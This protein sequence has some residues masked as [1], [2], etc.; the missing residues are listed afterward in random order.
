MSLMLII[1]IIM[2]IMILKIKLI[3]EQNSD[4]KTQLSNVSKIAKDTKNKFLVEIEILNKQINELKNNNDSYEKTIKNKNK[5]INLLERD[6]ENSGKIIENNNSEIEQLK[7]IRENYGET[8]EIKNDE[9]K[10][11][12]RII[13]DYEKTISDKNEQIEQLEITIEC[14]EDDNREY[15]E[16]IEDKKQKIKILEQTLYSTNEDIRVERDKISYTLKILNEKMDSF[17]SEE[18]YVD[19]YGRY[20]ELSSRFKRAINKI[21]TFGYYIQENLKKSVQIEFIGKTEKNIES[22]ILDSLENDYED[23]EMGHFY[24]KV[25]HYVKLYSRYRETVS[26]LNNEKEKNIELRK[27]MKIQI[28]EAMEEKNKFEKEINKIRLQIREEERVKMDAIHENQIENFKQRLKEK[29][30]QLRELD[31]RMITISREKEELK[32]EIENIKNRNFE[33]IIPKIKTKKILALL[34]ERNRFLYK[35]CTEMRIAY[36]EMKSLLNDIT[37]GLYEDY[38]FPYEEEENKEISYL[39]S[40]NSD[41]YIPIEF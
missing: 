17:P 30:M 6:N 7:R 35:Q 31:N 18:D 40:A 29:D 41:P 25:K 9:I 3:S 8:I 1:I 28:A 26:N 32:K 20:I 23:F 12:K 19:L 4:Y 10:Q 5:L 37:G 24:I 21:N 15:L 13:N 11:L 27:S 38:L 34:E 33:M 36:D 22:S 14:L 2:I 39:T 16:S